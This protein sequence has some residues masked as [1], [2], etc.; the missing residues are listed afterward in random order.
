VLTKA[1]ARTYGY[2]K[3]KKNDITGDS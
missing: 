1:E 2:R 3:K